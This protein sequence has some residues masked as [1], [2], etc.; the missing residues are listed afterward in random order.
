MSISALAVSGR[1]RTCL[2]LECMK[3]IYNTTSILHLEV[4]TRG[5]GI[6][7]LDLTVLCIYVFA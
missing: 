3:V 5:E 7:M 1:D 6:S 4:C 2:A